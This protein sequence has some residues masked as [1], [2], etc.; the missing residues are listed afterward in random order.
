MH[1]NSISYDAERDQIVLSVLGYHE[2]WIIDHSTTTAEAAG[3][4]GGRCGRGGDLLYR[5]GNPQVY[6]RGASRDRRLF[7]QHDAYRIPPGLPGEGNLLVFNNGR[8][9]PDGDWSSVDEIV[10]P[11]EGERGYPLGASGAY[12]P[13]ESVWSYRAENKASFFSGHISG[14]QRLPNGNTLV[15]SGES[16]LLFEVTPSA[17]V[18]WRFVSP[19]SAGP[20]GPP[21]G[22]PRGGPPPGRHRGP[23][24]DLFRAYRYGTDFPAFA[25]QELTPMGPIPELE[26]RRDRRPAEERD[27]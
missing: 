23:Q 5:W 1:T 7:A 10:V 25:G 12:G 4:D 20:A 22:A 3:H 19:V 27:R 17:D 9:R 14:A 8:G 15:C 6:D 16:G 21:N 2:I 11:P 26:A 13:S 18:V 24:N